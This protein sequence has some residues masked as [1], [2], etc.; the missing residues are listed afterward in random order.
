[1]DRVSDPLAAHSVSL[2]TASAIPSNLEGAEL[3]IVTAHGGLLPGNRYF[4]V[5]QDDADLTLAGS[6]LGSALKNVGVAV[7]FV[8]SGG[9]LDPHPMAITTLGLARR[10][11]GSGCTT[12][13]ASPWPIDSR[14]PSYWLP[15]FLE[16][17]DAGVPVIDAA[18]QANAR[19][20]DSFSSEFRDCL[21]MSV[22]GDP[23]RTKAR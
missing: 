6:D 17:W 3:V 22:Y 8:C 16:A 7:L 10:V 4:Q 1:M 18:F 14:I 19:V 20:R 11:L 23:L 15:T 13:I 5:V 12:V 2:D 21:A 9:R